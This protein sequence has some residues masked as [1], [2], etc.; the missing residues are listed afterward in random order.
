MIANRCGDNCRKQ[1]V[2]HP[3][4]SRK[5]RLEHQH[6]KVT[7]PADG[8]ARGAGVHALRDGAPPSPPRATREI[9]PYGGAASDG[10]EE[11]LC[12]AQP[13]APQDKVVI[14]AQRAAPPPGLP[15]ATEGEEGAHLLKNGHCS[16]FVKRN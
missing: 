16:P 7:G 6:L 12:L 1:G 14:A 11:L 13:V 10:A 5:A 15:A 4:H 2:F 9:R 3:F 8:A